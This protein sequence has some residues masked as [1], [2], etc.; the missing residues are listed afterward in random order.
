MTTTTHKNF[1]GDTW[2]QY[3]VAADAWEATAKLQRRATPLARAVYDALLK[4]GDEGLSTRD[5]YMLLQET[6]GGSFTRRITELQRLGFKI[7]KERKVNPL[8]KKRYTRYFLKG[9]RYHRLVKAAA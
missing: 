7:T 3:D 2:A 9:F 1:V 4:A 6:V 5:A 8:T